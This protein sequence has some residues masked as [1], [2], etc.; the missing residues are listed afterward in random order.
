MQIHGIVEQL[1][2]LVESS[3]KVPKT[4]RVL[5]DLDKLTSVVEQLRVAIPDEIREADEVIKAKDSIINQATMEAR[6]LRSAA[7]SDIKSLVA[8]AEQESR[9]KVDES[10]VVKEA[11]RKA[12]AIEEEGKRNAQRTLADAQRHAQ[13]I[14]SQAD[15][16]AHKQRAD[17]DQYA[18]EVLFN[19]EER[20]SDLLAQLRRGID[21]LGSEGQKVPAK[22]KG[23]WS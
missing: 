16:E 21:M 1:D 5:V 4:G 18:R 20:L 17:S 23:S 2:R 9:S 12:Q 14:V 11:Q 7:E 3:S 15:S 13:Q 22:A 6:R 8:S 19:L 10:Q